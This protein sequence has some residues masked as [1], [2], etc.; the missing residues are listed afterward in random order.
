MR[1]E[2][3]VTVIEPIA[4]RVAKEA[5]VVPDK[6]RVAAYA[7]VSTEQDEQQSS[8]EAQVSFYTKHIQANPAWEFVGIFAD[9]GISGTNTKKRDGFNEMIRR[10]LNGEID[11]ILTKSISRFARNTVDSLQ[12]VRD[13]KKAGVEVI[14][15]KESLHTFDPK[16]EVMLTIMS[17]LAQE[18]SRSISENVRWGQQKS[19]RDG[20]IN[21]PYKSFL[22]YR[23]GENG[24]P[25]IVEEEAV[26]VRE[27]YK[28]F[29]EGKTIRYI[30]DH[31]TRRG[32]P[33]PRG[34]AIWS[35][36]S[37]R[38]ILSNEKYKGDAILQKTYTVDY[39]TKEKRKNE[40]EVKQYLVENSHDP[41]IEPE[42]FDRVQE[43][44]EIRYKKRKYSGSNHPFANHLICSECG[45]YYG[46]KVWHNRHNTERYHV[47]YC[48][49]RYDGG[50]TCESPILREKEIVMAF[51]AVL[52]KQNAPDPTYSEERWRSEV[53]CVT[54]HPDRKLSFKL[55]GG[56]EVSVRI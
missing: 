26:I 1:A 33:T 56:T 51:E 14:F 45:Q 24:L 39:L 3:K 23:K 53:E 31:L 37:V 38:S 15:E 11:L 42:I 43:L 55:T 52:K 22:G 5:T 20:K 54:V 7:R 50:S 32:I 47:W 13:L 46:H 9:E 10:A 30:A 21:I 34:K 19:M 49:H 18:E 16:C 36:S 41:I 6:L 28:L 4:E 17:S 40:G 29:L 48:N 35:V 44:L 12:T 8:Y 2:K 27:I 25:E